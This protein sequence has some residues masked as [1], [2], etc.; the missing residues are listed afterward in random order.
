MS[1]EGLGLIYGLEFQC[2]ALASVEADT[3]CVKFLV[4]TQSLKA[5]NQVH[6]ITLDEE[7]RT[8]GKKVFNHEAGEVWDIASSPSNPQ[9]LSTRFS[10][11]ESDGIQK[12]GASIWKRPEFDDSL[13]L[14]CK[15]ESVEEKNL[16]I[17]ALSWM[18]GSGCSSSHQV[19]VLA[20][21]TLV[22]HDINEVTDGKSKIISTGRLEGKGHTH[23]NG[24]SWNP[25][26]NCQQFATINEHHVR[27]WDVRTMT[28]SWMIQECLSTTVRS[29]DFNPNKQYILATAGDDASVRFWD[30]R[31]PSVP[32]AY[33]T[34]D[35]SHWIWSVRY[36]MF[37]DQLLLTSS[38]DGHVVLSCMASISSEPQGHI[39]DD[40]DDVKG[41]C[42]ET[43]LDD[44]VI[45]TFDDHEDSVYA[46]QWSS[47][48]PWTFASLS[49][50]GRLVL[51]QVPRSIKFKILNL[52]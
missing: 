12:T 44:G 32:V 19:M 25:H 33:R 9:I 4:G 6:E 22:L 3:D 5:P 43:V 23:L 49:Y 26:Q 31:K 37:H 48:D 15:L 52:V 8:L 47:A 36:N 41:D 14:L 35:H 38:S 42:S 2:R 10:S 28:Q 39:I 46:V 18:P 13:E 51:N 50:D 21:N 34:N 7:A 16:E 27:G 30:I 45:R 11:V 29:I 24:G 20:E 17:A 40:E 1:G